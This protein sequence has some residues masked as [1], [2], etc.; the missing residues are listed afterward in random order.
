[1]SVE[2]IHDR[3]RV[4]DRKFLLSPEK[5]DELMDLWEVQKY[6]RDS[7]GDP[8]YGLVVRKVA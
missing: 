3:G 6:G 4:Y 1:V 8:D 7:Y 5:R 2:S